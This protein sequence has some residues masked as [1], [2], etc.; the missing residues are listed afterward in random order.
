MRPGCGK[1]AYRATNHVAVPRPHAAFKC[2]CHT[3]GQPFF[4]SPAEP[5][6]SKE[7]SPLAAE[8]ACARSEG[9]GGGGVRGR[10][11]AGQVRLDRYTCGAHLSRRLS[12][13]FN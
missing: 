7:H 4:P 2:V 12:L 6:A 5:A 13:R 11:A 9:R 3:D 8:T 1:C 10:A